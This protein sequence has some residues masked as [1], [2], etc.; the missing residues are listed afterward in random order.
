MRRRHRACTDSFT[1]CC[2]AGRAPRLTCAAANWTRTQSQSKPPLRTGSARPSCCA[3]HMGGTRR[4]QHLDCRFWIACAGL[5][6]FGAM[7]YEYGVIPARWHMDESPAETPVGL[8]RSVHSALAA[9]VILRPASENCL[10]H[11]YADADVD[12]YGKTTSS[13]VP[14]EDELSAALEPTGWMLACHVRRRTTTRSLL[15]TGNA[16]AGT[17]QHLASPLYY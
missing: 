8:A 11:D 6:A 7:Q 9:R 15:C 5:S 12:I 13:A 1:L 17:W 4:A 14:V 2:L 16:L 3:A 10:R